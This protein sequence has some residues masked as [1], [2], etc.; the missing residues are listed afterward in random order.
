[1]TRAI[2][3]HV[4][5]DPAQPGEVAI[6][7]AA[8]AAA[9]DAAGFRGRV[10]I[11]ENGD[12][13]RFRDIVAD[14]EVLFTGRKVDLTGAAEFAPALRWVQSQSAGVEALLKS[15]PEGLILTNASGVHGEKAAQFIL[16]A[17]LMLNFHIPTFADDRIRER[18]AP[19][20]GGGVQGRRLTLLGVGAIG[21]LAAGLAKGLGMHVTGVSR[22]G[23]ER[24]GLDRSLTVAELDGVLPETDFLVSSLPLTPA[25]E[26][27]LDRRRLALLPRGAG[28]VNV[29][30]GG[31]IDHD[32]LA[33][34]LLDGSLGGA[35]LDVFPIE[36]LPPGHQLWKVPRLIMTPHC[37]LDDHAVY[38]QRCLD[39]FARNLQ[40]YLAGEP[41]ENVVDPSLGY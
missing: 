38:R 39:L 41:L 36:P 40:R 25:T 19:I 28:L 6:S 7:S 1:M 27:L 30:R 31:V 12:P 4:E 5:N 18:W 21:A 8:L 2:R 22:T 3:I 34:R 14:A 13:A 15:F 33:D 10:E 11:T 17:V 37:S 29:G 24:P 16:T 9:L 35:V 23:G 26:R 20:Y 32:A